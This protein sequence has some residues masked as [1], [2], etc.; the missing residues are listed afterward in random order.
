MFFARCRAGVSV[1]LRKV[2]SAGLDAPPF[3]EAFAYMAQ[4][5][6]RLPRC[7]GLET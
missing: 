3:K 5:R 1:E 4:H 2:L 6:G 7:N